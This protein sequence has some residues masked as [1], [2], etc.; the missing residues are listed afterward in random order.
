MPVP[1]S[2]QGRET[3][4]LAVVNEWC[5]LFAATRES[6]RCGRRLGTHTGV[7]IS[8]RWRRRNSEW[9][10]ARDRLCRSHRDGAGPR[11]RETRRAVASYYERLNPLP[12]TGES[13]ARGRLLYLKEAKPMACARCHGANGDGRDADARGLVPAPRNFTCAET[14]TR[15]KDGQLSWV[16]ENGSGEY[17]RPS[18][19]GAQQIERPSRGTRSAAMGPYRADVSEPQIWQIILYIRTLAAGDVQQRPR[20]E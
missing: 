12:T 17:H 2:S 9:L 16:I 15:V 11:P 18:P 5:R 13:L 20:E 3:P 4:K 7:R 14:M 8:R 6:P 10:C 19:Q 1:H